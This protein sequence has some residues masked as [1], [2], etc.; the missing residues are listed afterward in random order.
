MN[1]VSKLFIITVIM[2]SAILQFGCGSKRNPTGGPEDT[3]KP[4]LLASLPAEFADIS[5]GVIELSFSKHLDKSSVTTGLY[6]YPL[7]Q[8]KKVVVERNKI[9][10]R[11]NEPL[12]QDT[13]YF[14]TLTSRIK[15]IRGNALAENQSLVY[16]SGTLQRNR[17]SGTVIYEDEADRAFP[18][19]F[20]LFSADSLQVLSRQISGGAFAIDV[21][22]PA[23]HIYRAFIDKNANSRYDFGVEPWTEGRV[24]V[25][26]LA[27]LDLIM[28]YADTSL[29]RIRTIRTA[30]NRELLVGFSEPVASLSELKLSI[31][32]AGEIPIVTHY[33]EA[34]NLVIITAEQVRAEYE[35]QISGLTDRKGNVNRSVRSSFTGSITGD[36]TPPQVSGSNPRNGTAV[37][38]LKP[39][40]LITFSEIVNPASINLELRSADGNQSLG[41]DR[42]S[43]NPRQIRV[44][45]TANLAANRSYTLTVENTLADYSGN[46]LDKSFVLN[47]LVLGTN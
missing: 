33:L 26:G 6:I 4:E 46:R 36:S 3:T 25:R 39:E 28:A 38:S 10:I 13:N 35:L 18:L 1:R 21:L 37:Q 30:S 42:L 41:F 12:L 23:T 34:E 29:P 19:Q 20:S 2:L 45:P 8:N 43:S 44:R 32:G 24:N 40:L 47:F 31:S 15:D 16:A 7:I 14:V 11:I 17:L 9:T 27:S 5:E 22:N